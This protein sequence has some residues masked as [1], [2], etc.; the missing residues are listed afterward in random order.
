MKSPHH[1]ENILRKRFKKIGMGIAKGKYKGLDAIYVTQNF[2]G[3]FVQGYKKSGLFW[4][5]I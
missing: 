4:I 5:I 1:R 2:S 3:T